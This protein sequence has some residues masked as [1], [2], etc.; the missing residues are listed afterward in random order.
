MPSNHAK[1]PRH[2]D[3]RVK[4]VWVLPIAVV[5]CIV[6]VLGTLFIFYLPEPGAAAGVPRPVQS[7][8][9]LLFL[10]I[11]IAGPAYGYIHLEY[12]SFTYELAASELVVREGVFTRSTSVIPYARI[13]N[14]TTRRTLL[15]R[16]IGLAT[17]QIETAGTN[18]GASEGVL[19]GVSKKDELIAEILGHVEKAKRL[20]S[21]DGGLGGGTEGECL[22]TEAELLAD[23]LK[24]LVQLNKAL[25]NH[26]G[27]PSSEHLSGLPKK[28]VSGDKK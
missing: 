13:Q 20:A 2:L 16:A 23:I 14:I 22:R 15:E 9:L 6:F 26:Y 27:K 24:E 17:L 19:P 5:L 25:S 10:L 11:F 8:G 12:L 4:L 21:E 1:G 28:Q 18:P 7:I 3:A